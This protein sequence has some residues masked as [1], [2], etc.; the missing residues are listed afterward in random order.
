MLDIFSLIKKGVDCAAYVFGKLREHEG[1][2]KSIDSTSQVPSPDDQELIAKIEDIS[3]KIETIAA[4]VVAGVT[5]KM[6]FDQLQ[7]LGSQVRVLKGALQFGK[8]SM[9]IT[10]LVPLSEQVQ[11][12]RLRIA[13]GKREWIGPWMI[14]E[15]IRLAAMQTLADD[16]KSRAFVVREIT[17][18]RIQILDNTGDFL[19]HTVQSPWLKISDFIEGRNEDILENLD[20]IKNVEKP[21]KPKATRTKTAIKESGRKAVPAPSKAWPFPSSTRN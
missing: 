8:E 12:S 21:A 14:A 13:E 16:E 18:F 20:A 7:K 1:S 9:I 4:S 6:E 17:D 3:Q 15:S 5:Q 11:Y 2:T 10:A 19:I